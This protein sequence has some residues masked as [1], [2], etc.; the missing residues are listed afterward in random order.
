MTGRSIGRYQIISE[1]TPGSLGPIYLGRLPGQATEMVIRK[2]P[3][4]RC[5]PSERVLLV[6]RIRRAAWIQRQLRHPAIVRF[7]EA[8]S[9]G[10]ACYLVSEHVAG[11]N[12]REL[13]QRQGPP[14][15]AQALG[16]CRELLVALD[17][18]H[19]LRYFDE[20]D[21]PLVGILHRDLQ[22]TNVV[23][24][25]TGR[26]RVTGFGVANLPGSPTYPF[27]G[28]QP[29]TL[30][31]LAP[32]LRRGAEPDP[33]ADIFSLGVIIYELMTG[34]HPYLQLGSAAGP[35]AIASPDSFL[36]TDEPPPISSIRSDIDPRISRVLMLA[37]DRRPAVRHQ[38]A[39][40]FLRALNEYD[41]GFPEKEMPEK[42][43]R[44]EPASHR[45]SNARARSSVVVPVTPSISQVGRNREGGSIDRILSTKKFSPL[46]FGAVSVIVLL[47]AVIVRVWLTDGYRVRMVS[48]GDRVASER[49]N[50]ATD[51]AADQGLVATLGQAARPTVESVPGRVDSESGF[52]NPPASLTE[53][54]ADGADRFA[55]ASPGGAEGGQLGAIALLTKAREADQNGRFSDALRL[56]EDYL[57]LGELATEARDVSI[58]VEKLK[59]FIDNL[60]AA[61]RAFDRGD[62]RQ[63][64]AAYA[65]ALRLRPY[66]GFAKA[67]LEDAEARLAQPAL[68]DPGPPSDPPPD[69]PSHSRIEAPSGQTGEGDW[70]QGPEGSPGRKA[71]SDG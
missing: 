66:S 45:S 5:S 43:L 71:Q 28:L 70:Y 40:T 4:N 61:K 38:T 11:T 7:Q 47:L 32:E 19:N 9:D 62:Y 57:Q 6:A 16:I 21:T 12:L 41:P 3:L 8:F 64:R 22:P 63:A 65:E 68:T 53:P 14:A 67:G 17:Y 44:A 58:Y 34:H 37:I 31:Y 24:D 13:L 42:N 2:V 10:Q 59:S 46:R 29:G 69:R 49:A 26:L 55:P 56:Y 50:T 20:S 18:A 1:L 27:T 52:P 33:R 54:A 51:P 30:E 15:P 23:V 48:P 39:A 36:N 60:E 25:V 35:G